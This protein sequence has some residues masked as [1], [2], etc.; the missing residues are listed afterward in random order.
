MLGHRPSS[1]SAA[2][3]AQAAAEG[4]VVIYW[5]KGCPFTKRLRLVLGKR[6]AKAVWVDIWADADA[7]AYV[8]S[9]NDGNETVPTVVIDGEAHANPPPKLVVD[10]LA[11]TV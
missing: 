8:R 5:R 2:E 10:A 7:A 3:G 9:V 4:K 11:R 6:G 1:V